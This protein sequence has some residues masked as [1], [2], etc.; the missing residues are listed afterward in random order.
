MK[1]LSILI[2]SLVLSVIASAQLPIN[3]LPPA[4]LPLNATDQMIVQQGG[5]TRKAPVSAVSTGALVPWSVPNGGTGNT[6][7]AGILK[8]NGVSPV[9]TAAFGDITSLWTG[10]CSSSNYL[11]GDGI[12]NAI[13]TG[14]VT[15]ITVGAGLISTPNP[16]TTTGSIF[17]DVPVSV[18]NGGSGDTTLSGVLKGNGVAPITSANFV[19]ITALWTGPCTS[20]NFLR[21]DGICATAGGGGSSPG[22]STNSAQYNAGGGSFGGIL[23]GADQA[24]MGT[25]T[26]PQATSIP[27]CGSTTQALAYSTTTHTYSCQTI[28]GGGGGSPG[29]SD[30]QIQFNDMGA[31][32]GNANFTY[33]ASSGLVTITA[34]SD[35]ALAT[36]GA[37]GI[38][39]V[40]F[41]G[42]STG[43]SLGVGIFAG[44]SSSDYAIL[45]HDQSGVQQTFL[46][47]GDGGVVVGTPTGA[48]KG[49]G[50]INAQGL[51]VNNTP[52]IT[53]VTTTQ[54]ATVTTG[55]ATGSAT[56]VTTRHGNVVS[57]YIE[58]FTCTANALGLVL[59][60]ALPVAP[61]TSQ[62]V[63][64]IPFEDN[65]ATTAACV[66]VFTGGTTISFQTGITGGCLSSPL[67][68]GTKGITVN[69]VHFSYLVN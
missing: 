17:L 16:I 12:C 36:V 7:L 38:P 66:F 44:T 21:G 8:G 62:E 2:C 13:N 52:V 3:N 68:T 10:P 25:A 5:S 48:D 29:G 41:N 58:P 33:T 43:A 19:D 69:A 6:T 40:V 32:G 31:F 23:L 30:T 42:S 22:G 9:G 56:V 60:N 63:A 15:S 39:S 18:I 37:A 34:T 47:A 45:V 20:T 57:G 1:K 64:M 50:A 53:D 28:S 14:T 67:G 49:L 61:V 59:S 26:I 11:R 51:F 4:N 35:A 54:T 27:N 24:L 65:S 55:C 46:L